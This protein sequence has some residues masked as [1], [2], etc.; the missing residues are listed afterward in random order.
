ML[1]FNFNTEQIVDFII[2][3]NWSVLEK[4]VGFLDFENSR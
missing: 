3:I 1:L 4:N 2:I